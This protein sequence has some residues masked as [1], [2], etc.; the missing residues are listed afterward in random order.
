M[1]YRS[2]CPNCGKAI[3]LSPA[4]AGGVVMCGACGF[5]IDVPPGLGVPGELTPVDESSDGANPP[6]PRRG[7]APTPRSMEIQQSVQSEQTDSAKP[8]DVVPIAGPASGAGKPHRWRI[9]A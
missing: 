2:R 7:V 1:R 3:I 9:P 6:E 4:D 5:R 8:T